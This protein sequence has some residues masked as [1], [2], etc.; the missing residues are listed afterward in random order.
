MSKS[1][2]PRA[3]KRERGGWLSAWLILVVLYN[4][5]SVF[6]VWDLRAQQSAISAPW[7]WLLLLAPSVANILAAIAIWKWKNWGLVLYAIS[8]TVAIAVGL[9]L[10]ASQ[11]I[12]FHEI[13]PLAILGYLIKDSRQH[14]D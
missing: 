8:T 11:L 2:H 13:I 10:T 4:A 3:G 7:F 12:V 9:L 5:F 1:K 6:L 14:F